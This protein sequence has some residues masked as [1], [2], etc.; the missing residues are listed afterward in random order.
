MCKKEIPTHMFESH[1]NNKT[2]KIFKKFNDLVVNLQV[3]MD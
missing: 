3:D 2:C 1:Y